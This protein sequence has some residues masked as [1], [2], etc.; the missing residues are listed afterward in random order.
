MKQLLK[1]HLTF[2]DILLISANLIPV[3]GVWFSGW[4]A[5]MMF[6]VYC[7]ESIIMGLCNILQMWLV[8]IVKKKDVWENNGSKSMVSGYVFML[9]FLFHYGFFIFVQMKI[10]LGIIS[11]KGLNDE[12]VTFLFHFNRFM[13][14]YALWVLLFFALTYGLVVVKDFVLPGVY[15][16]IDMSSLLFAPYGRI[17]VQQFVVIIG[18]FV[19]LFNKEGKIFILVFVLIKI[20]FEHMVDY[21]RIIAEGIKKNQESKS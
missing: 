20:F 18:S 8:T 21:K 11:I 10:F 13:P 5:K 17:F 19:L 7:M 12:V 9:F 14:S 6:L 15:K 3:W 16:T 1:Q 2:S 4:N